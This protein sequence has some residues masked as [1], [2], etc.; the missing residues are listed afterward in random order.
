[1]EVAYNEGVSHVEQVRRR[2]CSGAAAAAAGTYHGVEGDNVR[3]LGLGV[4]DGLEDVRAVGY[5]SAYDLGAR[6]ALGVLHRV[7]DLMV[8]RA[9]E[10]VRD[11]H[12][13]QQQEN[14]RAVAHERAPARS[15]E[16]RTW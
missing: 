12:H 3:D 2:K 10:R 11:Q 13:E 1:V 5:L 4:A 8:E 7:V 16:R 14:D 9:S 6:R 15:I